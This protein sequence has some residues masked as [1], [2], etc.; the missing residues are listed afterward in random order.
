MASALLFWVSAEKM[1]KCKRSGL[2][3]F[4]SVPYKLTHAACGVVTKEGSDS[5][6]IARTYELNRFIAPVNALMWVINNEKD[7]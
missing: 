5:F 6:I 1:R 4:G 2:D 3:S 7:S